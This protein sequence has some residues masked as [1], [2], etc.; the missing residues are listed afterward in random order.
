MGKTSDFSPNNALFPDSHGSENHESTA[1]SMEGHGNAKCFTENVD[2]TGQSYTL[3]NIKTSEAG[4]WEFVFDKN[5]FFYTNIDI[6]VFDDWICNDLVEGEIKC[7]S[8]QTEYPAGTYTVK[9]SS[10]PCTTSDTYTPWAIRPL[11]KTFKVGDK[12]YCEG[13]ICK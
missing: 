12:D 4:S 6:T 5:V 11:I 1:G 3:E 8:G 7:T 10:Y 2:N 13:E 9:F